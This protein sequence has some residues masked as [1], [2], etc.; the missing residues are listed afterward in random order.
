MQSYLR[1][2]QKKDRVAAEA[3]ELNFD[4]IEIELPDLAGDAPQAADE[5]SDSLEISF[6]GLED[7]FKDEK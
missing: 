6:E 1:S 5:V 2:K 3:D 4:D 7:L